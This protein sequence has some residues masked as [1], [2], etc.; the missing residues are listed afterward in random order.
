M[1]NTI[2]LIG[3][4]NLGKIPYT[5]DTVK[6]QLFL[7]RFKEVFEN[8]IPVDT[9]QWK[10]RPWC[11]L[12]LLKEVCFHKNAK[13][14]VSTNPGSA[15]ILIR[16]LNRIR[17]SERVFY[18]VVGGSL[19]E[20]LENGQRDWRVYQ[21]IARIFVQGNSMKVSM[22]RLGLS[23]VLFVPN[24]KYIDYMPDL[25]LKQN[26]GVCH[27]VFLSRIEKYKGCDD[28]FASIAILNKK[29]YQGKYDITFYG[30]TTDQLGY[31]DHFLQQ[32]DKEEETSYKGVL[33]LRDTKK[34]DELALYDVM[35]FP[36]Y[37]PG[38]GFPGVIIDAYIAG[39]PV[40]ASD[41]NLNKDVVEEGKTGWIIP[42]H[43]VEALADKMIFTIEHPEVVKCY[44]LNSRNKAKTYDS[45]SVL[46][47][48]RLKSI[49]LL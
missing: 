26:D 11:L 7:K 23:N 35:L 9:Y 36:T 41:W 13:I 6:N 1:K 15:D 44:S 29:G 49:G 3:A 33:N 30:K 34:Y 17:V 37:W 47:E 8:V 18:W 48:E 16:L 19:H 31:Y 10:K 46:S 40:I 20:S 5:G 43:D 32:I 12:K 45:R 28:I 38:E 42:T 39:L 22:E 25:S 14:I 2:I 4:I 24:S 27:F 21:K